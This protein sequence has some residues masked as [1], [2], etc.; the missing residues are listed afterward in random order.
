MVPFYIRE[1]GVAF[2]TLALDI[3][4]GIIAADDHAQ[5]FIAL[6]GDERVSS[7]KLSDDL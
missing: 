5:V 3:E 7:G 2:R 6:Y 1:I 4:H